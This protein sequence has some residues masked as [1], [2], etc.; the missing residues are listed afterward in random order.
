MPDK[1]RPE[2]TI[3]LDKERHIKFG[4][5]A[6]KKFEDV[7]GTHIFAKKTWE[8]LSTEQIQLLLWAGLLHED[9][10]LTADSIEELIDQYSTIGIVSNAVVKALDLAMSEPKQGKG[11]SSENP[12]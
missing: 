8:D 10:N 3:M 4:M 11:G 1:V 5:K 9:P 6:C 12:L 2:V 7:S